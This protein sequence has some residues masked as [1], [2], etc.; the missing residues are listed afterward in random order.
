[1]NK[2]KSGPAAFVIP[3]WTKNLSYTQRQLE[4]AIESIKLQTDD[5][6][7]III[8]DDKSPCRSVKGYLEELNRENSRIHILYRDANGGPGAS[9]NTGVEYASEIGSPFILY[10]DADD[11]S[12]PERLAQVRHIFNSEPDVDVVYS[13]FKMIDETGDVVPN[14]ELTGSIAEI[15]EGHQ[16]SPL[17][18]MDIWVDIGTDRGY[19]NLTSS[20]AVRTALA[21]AFPFPTENVSEDSYTWMMYSAGG[22]KYRYAPGIPSCYRIPRNGGSYSRV[23]VPNYYATKAAVDE[24]GFMDAIDAAGKKDPH[25]AKGEVREELMVKFY[26][27]LAETLFRE[28]ETDLALHQI[29][30]AKAIS[31]G[32]TERRLKAAA[33]DMDCLAGEGM[34]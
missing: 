21:A 4:A 17:Q 3:H 8:I 12:H 7:C 26:V 32:L 31:P 19:T 6:W 14:E 5:D 33:F 23:R 2:I 29:E 10:N 28:N 13:T 30:K 34:S 15:L 18:G 11:T 22:N 20:T 27:K 25:F 1:M 9:R 16:K 24:L